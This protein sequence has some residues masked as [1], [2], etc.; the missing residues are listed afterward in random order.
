[1]HPCFPAS[2][3]LTLILKHAVADTLGRRA[4]S[5]VGHFGLLCEHSI[6]FPNDG[7]SLS[8]ML[9]GQACSRQEN[10]KIRNGLY[11]KG[12]INPVVRT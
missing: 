8:Y 6:V 9:S 2:L 10:D 12:R 11:C 3:L 4:K 5:V 7:S 1:M